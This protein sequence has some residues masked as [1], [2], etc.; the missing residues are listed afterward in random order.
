[1]DNAGIIFNGYFRSES[2]RQ[3]LD[4]FEDTSR[5]VAGRR[6]GEPIGSLGTRFYSGRIELDVSELA[7]SKSS[8]R[9]HRLKPPVWEALFMAAG[10][11]VASPSSESQKQAAKAVKDGLALVDFDPTESVRSCSHDDIGSGVYRIVE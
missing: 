5:L 11:R 8:F 10:R 9:N 1:M 6:M 7:F 2:R 4:P 3:C